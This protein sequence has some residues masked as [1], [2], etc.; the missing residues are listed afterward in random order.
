MAFGLLPLWALWITLPYTVMYK[1][2]FECLIS[3]LWAICL[4]VEL[5]I[6]WSLYGYCFLKVPNCFPRG[7]HHIS[8]SPAAYKGSNFSVPSSHLVHSIFCISCPVILIS[9]WLLMLSISFACLLAICKERAMD[10]RHE[11][12]MCVNPFCGALLHNGRVI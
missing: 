6:M 7:L 12:P 1:F 3:I 10:L 8:F 5:L 4:G 9:Q 2:L 11:S